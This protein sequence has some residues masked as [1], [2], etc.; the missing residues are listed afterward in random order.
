[1]RQSTCESA[2]S[3]HNIPPWS[4]NHTMNVGSGVN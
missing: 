2:D 1:V 3:R 4:W